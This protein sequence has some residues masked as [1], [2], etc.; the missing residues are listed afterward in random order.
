MSSH[1]EYVLRLAD[2]ALIIGHRLS[3]WCSKGPMLEQDMALTNIALDHIGQARNLFQYAAIIEGA[4]KTEDDLA[5]LREVEDFR[6]CLLT[7]LPNGDFAMTVMRQLLF[8]AFQLPYYQ[9]LTKSAD[10]YLQG[11]AEKSVKEITYHLRWSG[12]W[13][14]RLGDGTAES[15]RRTQQALETL[16]PYCGE[17]WTPDALD[18]E[19][20]GLGIAP[21][22]NRIQP[23]WQATVSRVLSAATLTQPEPNFYQKGGKK[24][25][26]TEHLGYILTEMQYLQRVYPGATW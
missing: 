23:L 4:G 20:T 12:E 21:D 15:H 10:N 22:L 3:E 17:L 16:W 14:V 25:V 2:N 9:E 1:F 26:H 6:N 11:V 5:Y 18:E 24:G 13:V 7:E 8:S 19:M